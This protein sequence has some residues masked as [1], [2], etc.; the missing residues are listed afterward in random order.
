[1]KNELKYIDLK[2]LK[3]ST[4][5]VRKHGANDVGDLVAS[6]NS[7]GVIQ[8][9]LVRP[10]CE[11][12]DVVAGQRRL[13]AC[14][15]I[16]KETGS[17]ELVPCLVLGSSDDAAAIEASL[18]ENFARLPMD[19]M[20]QYEAF[21]A[22]EQ[23]G[24]SAE[25][26]ASHFGISESI[27]RRRLALGSLDP[28]IRKAYRDE[29]INVQT[30]RALTMA[31]PKKQK[32]WLK[33]FKDPKGNA[34]K[35][36]QLKAWLFG[37]KE[38]PVENA[39]FDLKDYKGTII[40]DLFSEDEFF[41]DPDKFWKCQ[42]KAIADL[43]KAYLDDGWQEAVILDIGKT[44]GY[45]GYSQWPKKEGGRVYIAIHSDGQVQSHEGYLPRKEAQKLE[46]AKATLKGEAPK[47][48]STPELTKAASRYC[49][50]H[51][52][53]AVRNELLKAPAIA[54][55]LM[56]AHA[57]CCSGN[58]E[59]SPETQRANN[60]DAI[61]KSLKDSKAQKAFKAERE[62]IKK[63][64]GIP[65][66]H[67]FM[68]TPWHG[69][70]DFLATFTRLFE[71]SDKDV[72]RVLTFVM[73]E[74]LSAGSESV[75]MLACLLDVEMGQWWKPD[76]PFFDLLRDKEAINAMLAEVA[77]KPVAKANST[78]TAKA[79][80]TSIQNYLSGKGVGPKPKDWKPRYMRFPVTG[81]TKRAGNG[82]TQR[83]KKYSKL[84]KTAK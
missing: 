70:P 12:F 68:F 80:K 56:I 79:Q 65:A 44:I 25:D 71:L 15:D 17:F 52:H 34:P 33:L 66:K 62:E 7:I 54:L 2:D 9:L 23:Q 3:L 37:G 47:P 40:P 6:I 83:W 84:F 14:Q 60:N 69:R 49:Q 75:E 59:T 42:N 28:A 30:I 4:A 31:T 45:E 81:Y 16:E 51:H 48:K 46:R 61:R 74:T 82:P 64:L 29:Q 5:N 27:V 22:L 10:N 55:R 43:Q 41:A 26:I 53:N 38:I 18:A 11:G 57:I 1:M 36:W 67:A 32:A 39:I 78:A 13:L 20:D 73:A 58:W 76:Q 77:S 35:G 8:P 50:L 24:Q 72:M 63:L 21:S 19:E